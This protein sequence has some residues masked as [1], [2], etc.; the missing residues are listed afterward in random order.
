RIGDWKTLIAVYE[1]LAA[2]AVEPRRRVALLQRVAY[3]CDRQLGRT[4]AAFEAFGR[5]L[6]EDP[7]DGPTLRHL[8]RLAEALNGWESLALLY[9][10]VASRPLPLAE[11]IDLRCRLARLYQER[12]GLPERAIATCVRVLDLNP[13]NRKVNQA[14]VDLLEREQ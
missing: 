11:Q 5:A 2:H 9:R 7:S 1:V 13:T 10:D 12:L 6:R 8:E 3:V 4:A 14:L